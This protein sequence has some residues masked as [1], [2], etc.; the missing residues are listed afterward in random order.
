MRGV[1][2][3]LAVSAGL[4]GFVSGA[5]AAPSLTQTQASNLNS[6]IVQ[7]DHHCGHGRHY[8]PRHHVRGHDGHMHWV[9]GVCVKNAP[10]PPPHPR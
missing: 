3:A 7:V 9:G 10:P 4:I 6:P 5:S 2:L 1:A 8:V